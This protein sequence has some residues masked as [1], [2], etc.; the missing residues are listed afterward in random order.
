M[1]DYYLLNT[2]KALRKLADVLAI[3]FHPVFLGTAV[4]LVFATQE[5]DLPTNGSTFLLICASI[6][7]FTLIIPVAA[8]YLINKDIHLQ[9][10]EQRYWP[11]LITFVSH[12]ALYLLLQN[13]HMQP[14]LTIGV[15]LLTLN[16]VVLLAFTSFVKASMHANAI[17]IV[18]VIYIVL[19]I[20][21]FSPEPPPL[22]FY[23][24]LCFFLILFSL[25]IWQRLISNAHTVKE[26][27]AGFISGLVSIIV[28]LIYL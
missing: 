22:Q 20:V 1:F 26:L 3:L 8:T 27:I 11:L 12:L 23:L 18:T 19:S 17:I 14:L 28:T 15:T 9:H 7:F 16:V 4:L 25:V 21:K 2:G 6:F 10:R 5:Y 13:I 24:I